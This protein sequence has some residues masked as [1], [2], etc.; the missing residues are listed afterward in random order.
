MLIY[1]KLQLI[2]ADAIVVVIQLYQNI[3]MTTSFNGWY[4]FKICLDLTTN[5]WSTCTISFLCLT[6]MQESQVIYCGAVQSTILKS[7][8]WQI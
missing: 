7:H 6:I 1:H 4:K 2:A 3:C 8:R 5:S